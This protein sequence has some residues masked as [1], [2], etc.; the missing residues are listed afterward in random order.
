MKGP[1][2]IK[3]RFQIRSLHAQ[4]L[5]KYL[6][7][8]INQHLDKADMS[9]TS[10]RCF[11]TSDIGSQVHCFGSFPAKSPIL[12]KEINTLFHFQTVLQFGDLLHM[13]QTH[14]YNSRKP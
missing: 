11:V 1:I 7:L 12:S 6:H 9:T 2:P 4:Q 13:L 8:H 10:G 5:W 14:W 3:T